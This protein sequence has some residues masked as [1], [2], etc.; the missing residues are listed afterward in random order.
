[1]FICLQASEAFGCKH[2]SCCHE[3]PGPGTQNKTKA[4]QSKKTQVKNGNESMQAN[5][6]TSSCC[7]FKLGQSLTANQISH[8]GKKLGHKTKDGSFQQGIAQN[9]KA[10]GNTN[11]NHAKKKHFKLRV[12][13]QKCESIL[14]VTCD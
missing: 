10:Q 12:E 1:M 9:N 6:E 8:S 5:W 4:K 13:K 11:E 3:C 14:D 7:F 2:I